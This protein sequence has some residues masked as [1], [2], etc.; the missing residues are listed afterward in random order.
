MTTLMDQ[1]KTF[2]KDLPD[3]SELNERDYPTW[4]NELRRKSF[5]RFLE[6]GIPTTKNEEWKY[7]NLAPL[8]QNTF[9]LNANGSLVKNELLTSYLDQKDLNIFFV[10]GI[11]SKELSNTGNFKSA[12]IAIDFLDESLLNKNTSLQKILTH[13]DIQTESSFVALNRALAKNALFIQIAPNTVY[14]KTLIHVVHVV[15][16][17]K[18]T[19]MP[20]TLIHVG[21]SSEAQILESYVSFDDRLTY[22]TNALTDI[23]LD[24][25]TNLYF[26]QA[27]K[28]SQKAFHINT[29]R[30][31]QQQ[32]SNFKAF[33]LTTAT[34]FTRNGVECIVNGEGCDATL[35]ALYSCFGHQHVDNHTFVDHRLPNGTSNQLYKGI[36]NESARAV[37]NGKI[38]VQQIA[39]KTNSYQLNKNLLLGK[40]SRVDT[41]PQLEI[42]ADDVKCTHGATIGQLDEGEIFY[43]QTRAIDRREAIKM[44]SRGFAD[45][46]LA[47]IPNEEIVKKLNLL[48]EPSFAI[49]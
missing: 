39:Q 15:T 38:F 23:Y 10:N 48:L 27:Q 33:T 20:Q 1:Q 43:L 14:T 6:L 40:N 9:Q 11:F 30:T 26:C 22:F 44:L 42:K 31:W 36:L 5:S 49:L 46:I 29:T 32:N 3:I 7:S 24:E 4:F 35:N 19:T 34:G 16:C 25:N 37:F 45:E 18:L 21:K 28:E 2:I 41:K 13:Y 8:T 47:T 12:G 17:D